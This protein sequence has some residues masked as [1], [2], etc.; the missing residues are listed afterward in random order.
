MG[1][2]ENLV[3]R[4]GVA[5]AIGLVVGTERAWRERD[6]TSGSRTAGIRTFALIGLFGGVSAALSQSL[7]SSAFLIA[8][9]AA[10]TAI[11]AAFK[12][13]EMVR[14]NDYSITSLIA[15][16]LVFALGALAVAGEPGVAGAGGIATAGLLALREVLH[17][18]VQRL[19]WPELRSALLLLSMSVI[20]LPL[21]PDRTL[22]PFDSINPHQIWIFMVLTATISFAGYAAVKIAGPEKGILISAL[23]GAL[24]S[25]TAV[26][27]ALARRSSSGE[28]AGL[29]AGGASLAAMVSLLRVSIVCALVAP[30]LLPTFAPAVVAAAATFAIA[31]ALLM[32]HADGVAGQDTAAG[33]PFDFGPLLAFAGLFAGVSAITGFL[34]KTVGPDSL[35]LVSA[36]AGTV[37]VDVPSLN[38]ARLAGTTVTLTAASKAIL[39]ALFMNALGRV[40]FA[41]AAG[42]KGFTVRFALATLAAAGAALAVLIIQLG[43]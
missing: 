27:L 39:L 18:A 24:V 42:T 20:V 10:L 30:S 31:G 21:L 17:R 23:G 19:T 43:F 28:P 1:L 34:L 13:R 5:L 35:Y 41:A 4:L 25:S 2:S 7:E 33:N 11:F 12:Y 8:S 38:A 14:E 32:R 9:G 22:D 3:F 15:A 16:M 36:V 6:E 29:L 40:G 26:T 37:D